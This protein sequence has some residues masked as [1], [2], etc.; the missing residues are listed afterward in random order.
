M[1]EKFFLYSDDVDGK[2]AIGKIPD[3]L[4]NELSEI[5]DLY[6]EEIPDK[7]K[8]AY[9]TWYKNMKPK[10]KEKVENIKE[11]PFWEKICENENCFKFSVDEMNELYYSNPP[12]NF[13]NIDLYGAYTNFGLHRDCIFNFDGIKLYRVL[14][15]L[16]DYNDNVITNLLKFDINQKINKYDYIVFDFD[17]T[18]HQVF[19]ERNEETPRIILKLHYIVSE[20]GNH[21]KEYINFIKQFY[22]IY[23][24]TTRYIMDTG[25]DPETFYEF[26]L[27]LSCY[28]MK[29]INLY[30]TLFYSIIILFFLIYVFKL[31]NLIKIIF[32]LL[33]LLFMIFI[34]HVFYY[35]SRYK[36]YNIK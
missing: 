19:K 26:F 34:I 27:G 33:L 8:A 12:N 29:P 35:W 7:S 1:E 32:L 31:N 18:R 24:Y 30:Y 5:S 15:G 36:I 22:I 23:E 2:V 21:S 4:R 20:N 25:T 16:T 6:Y 3:N 28:I 10:I 11:N 13:K 9:H 14:I 17:R